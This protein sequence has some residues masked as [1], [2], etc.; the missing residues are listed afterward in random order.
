MLENMAHTSLYVKN[1]WRILLKLSFKLD[2]LHLRAILGLLK[3]QVIVLVDYKVQLLVFDDCNKNGYFN[4]TIKKSKKKCWKK[5]IRSVGSPK[6]LLKKTK[7]R[8]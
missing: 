1:D 4:K 3:Q 6:P 5:W 7:H 8:G 2:W